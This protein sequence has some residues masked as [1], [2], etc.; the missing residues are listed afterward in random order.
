MAPSAPARRLIT[1]SRSLN[2]AVIQVLGIAS[3]ID[4][5]RLSQIAD[6]LPPFR[7]LLMDYEQFFLAQ[8]QQSA[9]CNALHHVEA[10]MCR[11]LL[12]MHEL[13]G[14]DLPLTQEFLAQM[15]GVQRTSVNGVATSLQK[16]GLISYMR[17]SLHIIDLAAVR[18]RACKCEEDV[19]SHHRIIFGADRSS[20]EAPAY[21]GLLA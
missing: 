7:T 21:N 6:E 5:T 15:M 19:R 9:A 3:V 8:V 4:A 14:P 12:R 13:A 18:Q 20:S 17:G 1:K 10:R 16:S 11:W 2:K